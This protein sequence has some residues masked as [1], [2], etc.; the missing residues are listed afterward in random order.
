[1]SVPDHRYD[2]VKD[3]ASGYGVRATVGFRLRM[4]LAAV[5]RYFWERAAWAC[6]TAGGRVFCYRQMGIR[7]GRDVFLGSQ[8]LFDKSFPERIEIR[9]HAVIGDR[10]IIFAHANL[11]SAGN[12]LRAQYPLVVK[13]V[14]I[15]AHAWIMPSCIVNPGVTIGDRSVVATG[16]VV[17]T[18]VPPGT[19][20]TP[21]PS[22]TL[23]LVREMGEK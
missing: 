2:V 19:F 18:S 3:L 10:C 4:Y 1:V 7:I 11:P 14:V 16:A 21:T 9:D 22:R 23:P 15:G 5:S 6:P 20:I 8:I 12:M 17:T 13:S